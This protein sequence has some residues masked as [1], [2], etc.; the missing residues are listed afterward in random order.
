[1]H[2]YKINGVFHKLMSLMYL[3]HIFYLNVYNVLVIARCILSSSASSS[4]GYETT[5]YSMLIDSQ[6]TLR[7]SATSRQLLSLGD[8]LTSIKLPNVT[9]ES[10]NVAD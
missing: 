8:S 9:G 3:K 2:I 10:I 1:M 7:G 6:Q 5:V 4:S